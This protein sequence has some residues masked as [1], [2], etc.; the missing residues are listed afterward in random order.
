MITGVGVKVNRGDSG[1]CQKP[2]R[3]DFEGWCGRFLARFGSYFWNMGSLDWYRRGGSS[4][5]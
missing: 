4:R 2:T 3:G 1:R 5:K